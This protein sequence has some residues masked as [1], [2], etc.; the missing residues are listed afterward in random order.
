[1]KTILCIKLYYLSNYSIQRLEEC[2]E[3]FTNDP[4]TMLED[5]SVC[6][7]L[8]DQNGMAD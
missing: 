2:V 7:M 6:V 1:M 3:G 8:S 5:F 4:K